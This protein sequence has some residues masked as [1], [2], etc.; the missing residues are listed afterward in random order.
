[1]TRPHV[2]DPTASAMRV[3]RRTRVREEVE[4]VGLGRQDMFSYL[5]RPPNEP[6]GGLV[7]C[8]PLYGEFAHNYRREV[9][10]ARTLASDGVAVQRFHYRGTGNSDGAAEDVTFD[11]MSMDAVVAADHLVERAGVD[12][13]AFLGTRL[14]ALI[15]A[16][17]AA[18][19]DEAPLI[20]WEPALDAE[21][22]FR[23]IAR[24]ALIRD[25]KDAVPIQ[26]RSGDSLAE[27]D[28]DDFA[29]VLGYSIHRNCYRSFLGHRLDEEVGNAPRALLLVQLSQ[30]RDLR[31]EYEAFV[32][33]VAARGLA[34]QTRAI[35]TNE[36]WWFIGD[37]SLSTRVTRPIVDTTSGWL[38]AT[39]EEMAR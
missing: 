15:A 10:L 28:G 11:S 27:L 32:G 39:L 4:F 12:Q 29:D 13:V 9:V 38:R 6:R 2:S 31:S 16:T 34:V 1:V 19:S 30:R 21:T 26:R 23:E 18:R 33:S 36:S 17:A 25:L 35:Y 7:I 5:H 20:L 8:S 24:N 3:D 37:P 22:Y 14:A